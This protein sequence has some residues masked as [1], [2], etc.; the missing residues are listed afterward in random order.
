MNVY[1]KKNRK[2]KDSIYLK[3]RSN[4]FWGLI[5]PMWGLKVKY[6]PQNFYFMQ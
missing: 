4:F 2:L 5:D 6:R 3:V 1:V